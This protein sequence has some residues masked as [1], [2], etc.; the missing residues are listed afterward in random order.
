L[1][2]IPRDATPASIPPEAYA[3]LYSIVA[4]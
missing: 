2:A 4:R 1:A 3:R